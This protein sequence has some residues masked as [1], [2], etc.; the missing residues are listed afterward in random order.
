MYNGSFRVQTSNGTVAY[1]ISK[2]KPSGEYYGVGG[3]YIP[4]KSDSDQFNVQMHSGTKSLEDRMILKGPI[5]DFGDGKLQS[6]DLF[7]ATLP[8]SPKT[9][10]EYKDNNETWFGKVDSRIEWSAIFGNYSFS[11]NN[12]V[13]SGNDSLELQYNNYS[14]SASVE[15][16]EFTTTVGIETGLGN[17][18]GSFSMEVMGNASPTQ[19]M[20][21]RYDSGT[22]YAEHYYD[23]NW[24]NSTSTSDEYTGNYALTIYNGS[25]SSSIEARGHDGAIIASQDCLDNSSN[26]IFMDLGNEVDITVKINPDSTREISTFGIFKNYW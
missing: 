19:G 6:R 5:D 25:N 2:Y 15:N 10:S 23:G 3:G 7:S 12:L 4:T 21:F 24:K 20:R 14:Y 26:S 22:F 16:Q 9:E 8:P 1:P 13:V 17:W 11:N 18:S